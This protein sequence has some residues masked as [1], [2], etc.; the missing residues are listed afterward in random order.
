VAEDRTVVGTWRGGYRCEVVT[1]GFTV[2]VDEPASAGGTDT[3][4]QPT[5]LLLA[6]VASCF[7]LAI[8]YAAK[9]RSVELSGVSVRVTGTYDGPR[10]SALT[11]RAEIG[12][13][14]ADLAELVAVAERVCYVT[15]T[16]REPPAIVVQLTRLGS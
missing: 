7:T 16:L 15:N 14:D 2:E 10:F 8:A 3:A 1:G 5:E 12:C 9:K 4:P 11:I 13:E 6:S